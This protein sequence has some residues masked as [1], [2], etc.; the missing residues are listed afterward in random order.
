MTKDKQTSGDNGSA[1]QEEDGHAHGHGHGHVH[2]HSGDGS[3][4][5]GPA[6][7]MD[8]A[9]A[10]KLVA[11]LQQL[12]ALNVQQTEAADAA[13]RR[14]HGKPQEEYAFWNTQPVPK[15]GE[16]CDE[17]GAIEADVPH[18]EIP[19]EPLVLPVG[20]GRCVAPGSLYRANL[21]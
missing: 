8:P 15:L 9:A 13:A 4:C 21:I 19:K 18:D 3:C 5:G 2:A 1:G 10:A 16:L 11:T 12:N 7:T 17:V 6:P 20:G 14:A